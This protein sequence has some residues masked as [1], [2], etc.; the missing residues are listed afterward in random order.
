MADHLLPGNYY[1]HLRTA[2]RQQTTNIII[3]R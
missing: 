1:V 2:N 3:I